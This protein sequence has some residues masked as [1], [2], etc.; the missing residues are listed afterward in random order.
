[1]G[2][3]FKA[4]L[5]TAAVLQAGTAHA[6]WNEAISKH[7]HVYADESPDDIR[8]F[9]TKLERF[10]AAVREARGKP[11][12]EGGAATQVSVY[13]LRDVSAIQDLYGAGGVAGFYIPKAT[14]SVA[15]ADRRD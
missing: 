11:D 4:L 13:V 9:A 10:D 8:A 6:A 7:F 15:V 12:V 2:K 3:L 5:A 14:G 1:M